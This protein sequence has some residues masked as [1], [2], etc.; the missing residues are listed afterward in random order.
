MITLAALVMLAPAASSSRSVSPPAS[1]VQVVRQYLGALARHDAPGVC[2]TFSAPFRAFQD[3]WEPGSTCAR[4]VAQAHFASYS[5]GHMVTRIRV[6]RVAGITEDRYGNLAVHLLLWFRFPCIGSVSAIPGCR[7]HFEQ[8]GDVVYLRREAGRWQIVKPGLIYAD[9]STDAAPA[10][11]DALSPPGDSSTVNRTA[12]LRRPRMACPSGGVS[13]AGTARSLAPIEL[14]PGAKSLPMRAAPWLDITQV[15]A[16]RLASQQLCV[17]IMLGGAP[18]VDTS[19]SVDLGQDDN[20]GEQV[21]TY[22][23]DIDGT[24]GIDVQLTD[25][26]SLYGHSRAACATDFGLTGDTLELI[27]SP[28]DKVFNNRQPIGL[29]ASSA[30]LQ[31][32]EPLLRHPLN[33]SDIA[34][35]MFG[36][37]LPPTNSSGLPRCAA[38]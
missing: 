13:A 17:S 31:T 36:L 8:R 15:S 38:L 12:S 24:G 33:A 18:K 21:D 28:G 5:P 3:G 20:G 30:S 25:A 27:V 35:S 9:T 10:G 32:G 19:Y 1:P 6:V 23:L 14:S 37:R 2:R 7:P 11:Y 29:D 22:S 26:R 4:R 34:P 16:V